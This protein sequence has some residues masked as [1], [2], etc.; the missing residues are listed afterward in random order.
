MMAMRKKTLYLYS[1]L[2]LLICSDLFAMRFPT[3]QP[4]PRA[5]VLGII[6][7]FIF[8]I[9]F[10]VYW[11]I[12]RKR[13]H[14]SI[15]PLISVELVGLW[16]LILLLPET[17]S[18]Y[19]LLIKDG[20][21]LLEALFIGVELFFLMKLVKRMPSLIQRF[22]ENWQEAPFFL[23]ALNDSLVQVFGQK[24]LLA[25]FATDLSVFYYSLFSWARSGRPK[26]GNSAFSY[27]KTGG[28]F[29]IFMM[30]IHVM[31]FEII[32]MHLLLRLWSPLA[33]W[34]VT[35]SDLYVLLLLIADYRAL[36]LCPII[37]GD[38]EIHIQKGL[39]G[40]ASINY[41]LVST[42]QKIKQK[43]KNKEK[44]SFDLSLS[45]EL[46]GEQ[47]QFEM[48]LNTPVVFTKFY[49]F[50]RST[51]KIYIKVDEPNAFWKA[52]EKKLYER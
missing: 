19:S 27:H 28:Y 20:I 5:V 34:I 13:K 50:K 32:A 9:P 22:K 31:V 17:Y 48:M 45:G 26:I 35:F 4:L 37:L 10:L 43:P 44:E 23:K 14:R 47:P 40:M 30:L 41:S 49:G 18:L 38:Q 21:V 36:R 15:W 24:R 8:T 52:I 7:D 33:A 3:F 29:G 1:F 42:V 12:L 16:F 25:F 2:F 46:F 6:S 39:R 11:F 51:R